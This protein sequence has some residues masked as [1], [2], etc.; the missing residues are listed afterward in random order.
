MH[1][2]RSSRGALGAAATLLGTLLTLPGPLPALTTPAATYP[3]DAARLAWTA[4]RLWAP[5]ELEALGYAPTRLTPD[6]NQDSLR[7]ACLLLQTA[8]ELDP[9]NA[10]APRDL[11][12]LFTSSALNDPGR[13]AD[14]LNR[15]T[16]LNARDTG[17]LETW[18]RYRLDTLSDR[19]TR[20]QFLRD[21]L[22]T[23]R[24][25]PLVRSQ[26]LTQLGAFALEKGL[27]EDLPPTADQP[28]QTG[29]RTFFTQAVYQSNFFDLDPLERFLA[30]PEPP[31]APNLSDRA[32]QTLSTE[33][34]AFVAL[35]WRVRLRNNPYDLDAALNLIQTLEDLGRYELAQRYYPHAYRL[36]DTQPSAAVSRRELAFRQLLGA[37][38]AGLYSSSAEMGQTLL[39]Q[40]QDDLIVAGVTAQALERTGRNGQARTIL[41]RLAQTDRLATDGVASAAPEKQRE[42]AWFY[43]FFDPQPARALEYALA[44]QASSQPTARTAALLAYAHLLNDQTPQAEA[45]LLQADPN[46]PLAA[47]TRAK[48]LLARNDTQAAR[49]T[50]ESLTAP[51]GI[52]AQ[53]IHE[54]LDSLPAPLPPADPATPSPAVGASPSPSSPASARQP[55]DPIASAFAAQFNDNDLDMVR[56]PQLALRCTLWLPADSVPFDDPLLT[57]IYLTNTSDLHGAPTPVLLGP[58]NMV[59]PHLLVTAEV[60]PADAARPNNPPPKP[61][62]AT[63]LLAH[64]YLLQRHLLPPGASIS[65]SETLNLDPLYTLL[66][67]HPQQTYRIS[68]R[69]ILDPTPDGKGSF[70]GRIPALQPEPITVLR[71]GFV[72]RPDR[73]AAPLDAARNGSPDQRIAAVRLLGALLREAELAR[74]RRL[75]Y[76]PLAVDTTALRRL[77]TQ[78]LAHPDTRVRAWTAQ[79]LCASDAQ[80]DRDELARLGDLLND[81][82]WF[83]RLLAVDALAP[84]ADLTD[85]LGWAQDEGQ[86]TLL[87]RQLL[88][89]QHKPWP[90]LDLPAP[91]PPATATT[92]APAASSATTPPSPS[93]ADRPAI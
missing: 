3:L 29:A 74:Q 9:Q 4:R 78:N 90:V 64:R 13:A 19:P 24:D 7:R 65:L 62:V 28:A 33:R 89:L 82:N 37:Y 71:L 80:L 85:Y 50:L 59:D 76:R 15:C 17:T 40:D 18:I 27:V 73:L 2:N 6:Q 57:T 30:L 93:P 8:A 39:R 26:V 68:F 60:S 72:P 84:R 53:P 22:P 83:A 23:L 43:C 34:T 67:D 75:D 42:W 44:A 66:A 48:L 52:L 81:G 10:A 69:V 31:P 35:R 32:R 58:G 87:Q 12:L 79:A 21:I 5:L 41:D 77:L 54:L 11:L 1:L 45:S 55:L 61:D 14:A 86:H 49:Q 91:R 20:E 56:S 70:V 36:L 51:P 92:T 16:A 38:A 25:D 88:L 63:L 46:D 47:L